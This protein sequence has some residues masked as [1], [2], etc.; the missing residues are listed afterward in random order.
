MGKLGLDQKLIDSSRESARKIVEDV[1][2]FIDKHTT[3]STERAIVR[4]FGVDGVDSI[5]NPLPNVLIDNI[6]SNGGLTRG[7]A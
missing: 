2:K 3:T 5:D 6:K 7:A 4:L 1:Q